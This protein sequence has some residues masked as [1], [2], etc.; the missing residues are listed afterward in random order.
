MSIEKLIKFVHPPRTS[1][2]EI[3]QGELESVVASYGPLPDDY[4]R[5]VQEYGAGSFDEFVWIYVPSDYPSTLSLRHQ[6]PKQIDAFGAIPGD[7]GRSFWP[8]QGGLL[9]VGI[10]DNGDL[11]AWKTG[12]EPNQWTVALVEARGSL[13]EEFPINLTTFLAS[14]LSKEVRSEIFPDDFPSEDP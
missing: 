9:P 13:Y 2:A 7:S 12:G 11:I 1:P 10:T 4:V 14:V 8:S 3:D 5:L 6:A